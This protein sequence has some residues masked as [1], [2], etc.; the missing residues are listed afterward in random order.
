MTKI[1]NGV[2]ACLNNK[3]SP[4]FLNIHY[5]A[6]RTNIASLDVAS[7]IPCKILSTLFDNLINDSASLFKRSS[8][9]KSHLSELQEE[10]YD[11]QKSLKIH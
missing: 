5:V 4:F 2:V 8:K 10:S 9:A 7:S 3:I 1:C 6:H 11:I